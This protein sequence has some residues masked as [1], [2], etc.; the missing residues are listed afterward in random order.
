LLMTTDHLVQPHYIIR[1]EESTGNEIDAMNNLR[2]AVGK[3]SPELRT[4]LLPTMY[5]NEDLIPKTEQVDREVEE[6]RK[7]LRVHE[8]YQILAHYCKAFN[9]D[10]VDLTYERDVNEPKDVENVSKFFGNT[11]P[12]KSFRHTHKDMTKKDYF[13]LA[14]KDGWDDLLNLTSFCRRPKKQDKPCG[15]CGPCTDAVKNGLGF[16]LPFISR[17]KSRIVLPFRIYYRK[18]YHKHDKTWFFKMIK[19]RFEH[20]F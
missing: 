2:R 12:F 5:A 1:H 14:I 6:L 13:E 15:V 8:Q 19:R 20:R 17:V 9:I 10:E 7:I 16:R 11:S 18:N 4:R 3:R